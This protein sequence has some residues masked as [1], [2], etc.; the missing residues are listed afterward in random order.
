MMQKLLFLFILAFFLSSCSTQLQRGVTDTSYVSTAQPKIKISATKLPLTA[1]SHRSLHF[2]GLGQVSGLPIDAWITLYGTGAGP[3]VCVA[4][5]D[6]PQG[7]MWDAN[8]DQSFSID[9]RWEELGGIAFYAQTYLTIAGKNPFVLEDNVN[10]RFL[11]RSYQARFNNYTS[12]ILIVYMEKLPDG[13]SSLHSLPLGFANMPMAF[14]TR[15][16]EAISVERLDQQVHPIQGNSLPMRLRFFDEH[17][18]G[19]AS[20]VSHWIFE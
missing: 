2:Y 17:F 3:L 14:A 6:V 20:P 4:H 19:T 12:K 11:V 7:W 8:L 18:L 13:I 1:H 10:D 16:K 15:A 9:R 5:G